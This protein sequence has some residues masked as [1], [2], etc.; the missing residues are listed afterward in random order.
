MRKSLKL[1]LALN[2]VPGFMLCGQSL[3]IEC[4]APHG[5]FVDFRGE[6]ACSFQVRDPTGHWSL[7]GK[8]Q[9]KG[10]FFVPDRGAASL[11]VGSG[12]FQIQVFAAEEKGEAEFGLERSGGR[13]QV[14]LLKNTISGFAAKGT[15]P[16]EANQ[17]VLEAAGK[18]A[19]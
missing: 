1:A 9:G 16:A 4:H 18:S 2:L 17:Y 3:G 6:G 10:A 12:Q 19:R 15:K 13:G 8:D 5:M 7:A 11:E 14:R